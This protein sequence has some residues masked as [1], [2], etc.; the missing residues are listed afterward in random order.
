MNGILILF[1]ILK[2]KLMIES[3]NI[4]E[5]LEKIIAINDYNDLYKQL[6]NISIIDYE[7]TGMGVFVS[8][9]KS[10]LNND[11]KLPLKG[12]S[13]FNGVVIK[14]NEIKDAGAHAILVLEDGLIEYLEIEAFWGDYPYCDIKNYKFET[15]E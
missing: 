6:D 3:N 5:L 10:V 8:F 12:L 2:D 15:E 4:K 7:Y 9:S 1:I 11:Y 14:S 13:K